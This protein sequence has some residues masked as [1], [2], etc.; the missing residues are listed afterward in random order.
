MNEE[1]NKTQ[2][3][4]DLA[5][6]QM[7]QEQAEERAALAQAQESELA[8]LQQNNQQ[9]Y[10]DLSQIVSEA[11]TRLG[12]L[13]QKDE[14]AQKRSNAFRYIAGVGD[15]LSGLANLVGTAHGAAN[16]QQTYN[17]GM[18]AQRAEQSRK[19]RKLEMDK[20]SGRLD[21]MRAREKELK[22]AGSLAEAELKAKQNREQLELKS[23]Q[24]ATRREEDWKRT[25]QKWKE[26]EAARAQAFRDQQ[27]AEEKRQFN[28]TNARLT[29][30][31]AAEN[32]SRQAIKQMELEAKKAEKAADPKNQAEVLQTNITGIRD[33]LAQKMG[34]A[35]YN[36][37]LRYQ[38]V[39][40]WGEDIDGQR[41]KDSKAIRNKRA[42]ENPEAEEF[43]NLLSSPESLTEEQ[44]R[45]LVG[46]SNVF[47]DAISAAGNDTTNPNNGKKKVW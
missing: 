13:K 25:Q 47:A 38:N 18:V 42:E 43:L 17:G 36:E 31:A 10:N 28:A 5:S 22:T 14:V 46:A 2:Q 35:D 34:Y 8:G 6:I 9:R 11:E 20:I 40:G 4:E 23:K 3:Q 24:A 16:Q 12:E 26:E 19:E 44:I 21:E 7:K 39:E 41:N 33:E 45:M 32:E 30:A 37:Y 29:E 27:L 15:T 1:Q